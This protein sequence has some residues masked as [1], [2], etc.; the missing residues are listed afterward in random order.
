M[1]TLLQAKERTEFKNSELRRLRQEGNIPAVVYGSKLASKSVY[2]SASEFLKAI[3]EVGRN[4]VISLDLDGAKQDVVL[5]D[6]Q[7]TAMKKEIIH[8]DFLAIDKS[9]VINAD[10]RITLVGDAAG[11]KDGGVMQQA[12]HQ[13]S[14]TGR[15]AEIPQE[16]EVDVTALQVGETITVADLTPGAD[17]KVN[18]EDEEVIASILPPR[19]EEEINSGEQQDGGTPVNEE[20][21]ETPAS[22]E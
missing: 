18:H 1:S 10:V 21:R 15:P 4:G 5:S 6:Y 2:I 9:S 3:K 16:L 11:V 12:L 8:A 22:G 7:E 13:V 17:L 20:G 14:V 19:Q